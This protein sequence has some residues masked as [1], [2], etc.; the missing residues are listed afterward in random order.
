MRP[1][2][3][4]ALKRAVGGSRSSGFEERRSGRN[5]GRGE[6]RSVLLAQLRVLSRWPAS[7]R[8]N[9]GS[10]VPVSGPNLSTTRPIQQDLGRQDAP[11]AEDIDNMRNSKLATAGS[12]GAHDALGRPGPPPSPARTADSADPGPAPAP[13]AAAANAQN[14]ASRRAPNNP[15]EP[16]DPGP[17]RTPENSLIVTNP[18]STQPN[19]AKTAR[20]PDH[21]AVDIPPA[22]PPP[23]NHT[24]I[25]GETLPCTPLPTAP[26]R[27]P[28]AAAG[29]QTLEARWV[30]LDSDLTSLASVF[31]L[32][33]RA[34][35][36][37]LSQNCLEG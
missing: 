36:W 13:P 25:Q 8:E 20:K 33:K 11:L 34:L 24:V 28:G 18:S 16:S 27:A 37:L 15:G 4:Q 5:L 10:G 31:C 7:Y 9:Q 29:T 22:C 6:R 26:G 1:S 23:L 30:T 19:S 35:M 3:A 14:A 17:P 21:T 2:A 12:A 32:S